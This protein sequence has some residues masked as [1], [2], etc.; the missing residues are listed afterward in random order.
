MKEEINRNYL[1]NLTWITR[2]FSIIIIAVIIFAHRFD[3][4]FEEWPITTI[5]VLSIVMF[6]YTFT[7]LLEKHEKIARALITLFAVALLLGI[8]LFF[9][10]P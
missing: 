1:K 9:L 5:W 7:P 4:W 6:F 2:I 8:I 3:A 10:K